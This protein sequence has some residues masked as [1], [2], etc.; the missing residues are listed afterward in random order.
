MQSF[1]NGMTDR[2]NNYVNK[3]WE[4]NNYR[5]QEGRLFSSDARPFEIDFF[6]IMSQQELFH[7]SRHIDKY[8]LFGAA[9]R[10]GRLN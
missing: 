2:L 3:W 8:A 6:T 7:M 4:I 10:Q 1:L 9:L 5:N